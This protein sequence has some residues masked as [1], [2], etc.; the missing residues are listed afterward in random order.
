M[1]T[2]TGSDAVTVE[3]TGTEYRIMS[4]TG[5]TSG[6]IA[7]SNIGANLE[8]LNLAD[9]NATSSWVGND[10]SVLANATGQDFTVRCR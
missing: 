6:A 1:T 3:W 8:F 10:T 7:L 2:L 9:T 5:T 4:N